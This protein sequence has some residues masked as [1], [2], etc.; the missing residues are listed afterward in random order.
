MS[1]QAS[2]TKDSCRVF[3]FAPIDPAPKR[4]PMAVRLRRSKASC[5][6]PSGASVVDLVV[7]DDDTSSD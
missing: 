7:N 6:I 5:G 4:I 3:R 2:T 1:Y